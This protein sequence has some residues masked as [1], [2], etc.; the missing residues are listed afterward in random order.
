MTNDCSSGT[1]SLGLPLAAAM[2]DTNDL[3]SQGGSMQCTHCTIALHL[4]N[5]NMV[6]KN[7]AMLLVMVAKNKTV[8]APGIKP[9]S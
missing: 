6:V 5:I 4:P 1:G 3:P 7:K 2:T 9:C 8:M